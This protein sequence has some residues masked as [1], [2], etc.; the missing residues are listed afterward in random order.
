MWALVNFQA[1]LFIE[2]RHD[3][4]FWVI[5]VQYLFI[6]VSMRSTKKLS[7]RAIT[8]SLL[9]GAA[10]LPNTWVKPVINAVVLP[11]HAQTSLFDA[12]CADGIST[13][14]MTDYQEN[15]VNFDQGS[16]Q[17]QVQITIAGNQ[18]T[19]VT[20]WCVINSESNSQSRGRVTDSGT[21]DLTTGVAAT[22]PT[23][24]PV[25]S[26][27]HGGVI[28]LANNLTQSFTLDCMNSN[29]FTVQ[30]T[31]NVYRFTLTRSGWI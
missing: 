27:T 17:S 28:N 14:L 18:I 22:S 9:S 23:G 4:I 2:H 13:W 29:R 5:I 30:D 10:S 31:T 11:A 21:V 25:P 12:L 1:V 16:P 20:D 6:R 15:G 8:V 24:N 3:L 19:L 26:P 7:R